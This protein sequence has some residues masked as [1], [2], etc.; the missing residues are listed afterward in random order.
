[1]EESQKPWLSVFAP[2]GSTSDTVSLP[3]CSPQRLK[4]ACRFTCRKA[5][6]GRGDMFLVVFVA[7]KDI[8][9]YFV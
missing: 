2:A 4:P 5:W 6:R 8:L 9:L 7:G 3:N 1:V